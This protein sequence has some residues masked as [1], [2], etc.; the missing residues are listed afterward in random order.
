VGDYKLFLVAVIVA[1]VGVGI[2]IGRSSVGQPGTQTTISPLTVR[3]TVAPGDSL[4]SLA[5]RYGNPD[6]YIEDNVDAMAKTNGMA[7]KSRLVV[8]Q[9]LLVT[10][11]NPVE[12]ASLQ[13]HVADA[14]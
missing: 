8:G 10:V 2:V 7:A 9:R 5:R 12:L 13:T 3:V 11:S 6:T 4:W 1:L 14:R